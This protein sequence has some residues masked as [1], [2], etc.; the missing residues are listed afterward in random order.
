PSAWQWLLRRSLLARPMATGMSYA[1]YRYGEALIVVLIMVAIVLLVACS[2]IA[3][4]LLARATARQNEITTR[5]ALGASRAR[6]VRQLLTESLVLSVL[7]TCLGLILAR[8]GSQLL[9]NS[10]TA[11]YWSPYL[12]L[13]FDS[14]MLAF[15]CAVTALCT[16]LFGALPAL[17]LADT[18]AT[19]G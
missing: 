2:N 13:T 18:P 15:V 14:R 12:D 19:Y 8:W 1:R 11:S 6:I 10:F 9:V 16:L 5:I 4:L 17:R 7:G 3:N